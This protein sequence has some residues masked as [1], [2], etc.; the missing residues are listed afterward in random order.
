MDEDSP[1]PKRNV[2]R[3][4]SGFEFH[5]LGLFTQLIIDLNT[6]VDTLSL[7][8]EKAIPNLT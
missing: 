3:N 7:W 4:K 8:L 5:T 1:T 6:Q 2:G